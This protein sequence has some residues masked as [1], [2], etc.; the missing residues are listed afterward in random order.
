MTSRIN[1][2]FFFDTVRV[3][4]FGGSLK[5]S[6]VAGMA[7][8]LD[9]WEDGYSDNDDRW[10]AYILATTFHEVDTRMQPINEYGGNAYF[11]RMY[12]I[13]GSRPAKARE[14]GNL[15]PGDGVRY[16]GRGFV[17]LTGKRNYADMARRLGVDLIGNPDLALD[18]RIATRIMFVGMT[19]GTFTGR[20]LADYFNPTR[21]DWIQA[22]RIIN[23]LDKANVIAGHG[24]RFY[25][26]LSYTT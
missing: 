16:R 19:L 23:G 7:A 3:T 21:D 1:R 6:Q 18:T 12:D 26:A 17:Q 4:L 24:K 14:L 8:I 5:A 10:L 22:R 2:K 15:S 9:V 11:H 13:N 20:K 25:A